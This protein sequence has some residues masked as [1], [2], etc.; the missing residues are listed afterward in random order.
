MGKKIYGITL[1]IATVL[2]IGVTAYAAGDGILV[3]VKKEGKLVVALDANYQPQSYQDPKTGEFK[4][5]DVEVAA[6]IAKR[7]GVEV[8]YITPVWDTIPA[9]LNA[10]RF[11]IQVNSMTITPERDK[12]LDFPGAYYYGAVGLAVRQGNPL[13]IVGV[14]DLKGKKV[15]TGA[16][17]TYDF[18][19]KANGIEVVGY[20]SEI[21][22][23]LDVHN[24]RLDAAVAP[25]QAIKT[26]VASGQYPNLELSQGTP[27][28]LERY[29]PAIAGDKPEWKAIIG[30]I[31]EEMH[32]DGT[33]SKLAIK[34][35]DGVDDS[36]PITGAPFY[37]ELNIPE[38]E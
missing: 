26:G 32:A 16:G 6:E 20:E 35:H 29:S 11:P 9:A 25:V 24:G 2:L 10:G 12:I 34:W 13:N 36:K 4:G 23:M 33:L 7:L 3:K 1:M 17:T 37:D 31:I 19:L 5:F 8:E 28:F 38:Y 22:A 30:K 14:D 27:L 21:D 15:G 18:F